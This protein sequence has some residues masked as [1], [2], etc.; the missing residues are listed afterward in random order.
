MKTYKEIVLAEKS[1][2]TDPKAFAKKFVAQFDLRPFLDSRIE[3]FGDDNGLDF[4]DDDVM[5][6]AFPDILKLLIKELKGMG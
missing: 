4:D 1:M 6:K 3:R 2:I 5:G